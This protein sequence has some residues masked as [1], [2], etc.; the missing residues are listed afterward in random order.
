[1][2]TYRTHP[3]LL[4]GRSVESLRGGS[5]LCPAAHAE[6][7]PNKCRAGFRAALNQELVSAPQLLADWPIVTSALDASLYHTV[8]CLN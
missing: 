3:H 6:H 4:Q 1:M 8:A 7:T 5:L 2:K